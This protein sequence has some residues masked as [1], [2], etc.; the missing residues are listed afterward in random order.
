M[1]YLG[2]S[3]MT[4]TPK[5]LGMSEE[6]KVA[7]QMAA[8]EIVSKCGGT[9]K[10]QYVLWTDN[11]LFSLTEFPDEASALLCHEAI[12]VRGS[13]DMISQRAVPLDD[14]MKLYEDAKGIAGL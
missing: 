2:A 14:A 9:I 8:Y 1:A 7:E 5:Y 6:E 10:G 4:F 12:T 11:C 13:F 3:R